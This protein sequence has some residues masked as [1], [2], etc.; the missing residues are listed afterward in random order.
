MASAEAASNLG[1]FDGVRFGS[2]SERDGEGGYEATRGEGFG[3]EVKKR[4]L[5]GGFALSAE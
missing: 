4:I 5:V 1:R 3:D 2:R